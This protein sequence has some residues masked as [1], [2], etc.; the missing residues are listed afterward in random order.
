M[1]TCSATLG[2]T[3]LT[4]RGREADSTCQL[5][6][7]DLPPMKIFEPM[8]RELEAR[9]SGSFF[10][11]WTWMGTWLACLDSTH[12]IKLLQAEHSGRLVGL[13]VIVVRDA[14]R[15]GVLPVRT[16]H[17]HETGTSDCDAITVEHNGFLLER[18]REAETGREMA[19]GLLGLDSTLDEFRMSAVV[20]PPGDVPQGMQLR[21]SPHP[22]Y[23]V[24]LA[25]ITASGKDFL[26][27]LKQRQ[28]YLVRKSIK[29]LTEVAPLRIVEA[30]SLE[31]ARTTFA[32]LQRLHT[33][34]WQ[35]RND[36]GAFGTEFQRRFHVQLVESAW[37]I[38]AVRLL[39]VLRGDQVLGCFYFFCH[40]GWVHYYQ[41][42]IDYT[43]FESTDS[44]GLA[45][46]ACAIEHFRAQGF[47]VYDFMAGDRQYKRTLATGEI[48]MYWVVLQRRSAK[49]M[50]EAVT[51]RS[52]KAARER[53]LQARAWCRQALR[54]RPAAVPGQ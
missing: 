28:R 6:L 13:A 51:V 52:A 8:W 53:L 39:S 18:E 23:F 31:E 43:L 14:R 29:K 17:L 7:V 42:G 49:M 35:A 50:L 15:F 38:G 40:T 47:K 32:N 19:D 5:S 16:A 36:P 2:D 1:N 3:T 34:Y 25:Q 11:S 33:A 41:S 9:S 30:G 4:L 37:P 24:D 44:P 27:T 10:T 12:R 54:R 48:T 22:S 45:A 46:H 20:R 21:V 26:A